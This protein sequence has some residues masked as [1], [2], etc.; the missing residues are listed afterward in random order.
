MDEH[1]IET[2]LEACKSGDPM[3]QVAAII[4]LIKLHADIVALE[5]VPLLSSPDENVREESARALGYLGQKDVAVVGPALLKALNDS[6][7]LVR[8]EAAEALGTLGYTPAVQH[9]KSLLHNDPSWLVRASAAEALG[10]FADSSITSDLEQALHDEYEPVRA[11]SAT[12]LGLVATPDFLPQLEGY[13]GSENS[14]DV[15]TELL[16]ASY[17]LGATTNML[18]LLDVLETADEDHAMVIFNNLQDLT[19]WKPPTSL[20]NDALHIREVLTKVVQRIPRLR[21]H[22]EE[23]ENNLTKLEMQEAG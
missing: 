5:L 9:L 8:E 12:S 20:R 18:Q 17:R 15:K 2:L 22:A 13:I 7:E 21:T 1:T 10:N 14:L 23:I 16:G 11:Y 3:H 6:E 19:G 4:E